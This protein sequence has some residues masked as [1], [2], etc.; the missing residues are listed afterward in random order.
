MEETTN[1]YVLQVLSSETSPLSFTTHKGRINTLLRLCKSDS[2]HDITTKPEKYKSTLEYNV[3]SVTTKRNLVATIMLIN[4]LCHPHLSNSV[5]E[6]WLSYHRLLS[7]T[8]TSSP[9]PDKLPKDMSYDK[10]CKLSKEYMRTKHNT[11]KVY[12][13]SLCLLLVHFIIHEQVNIADLRQVAVSDETN[14]H[15]RQLRLIINDKVCTLRKENKVITLSASTCKS[16]IRSIQFHP[17]SFLFAK[18]NGAVMNNNLFAQF[19][20]RATQ[21]ICGTP[22][23]LLDLKKM[24]QSFSSN[25]FGQ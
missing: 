20:L 18:H 3:S 7:K 5:K 19:I 9:S 25:V 4:K 15:D 14:I 8:Q 16:I 23:G 13:R 21:T 24:K 12:K 17:R 1:E 6:S 22:L 11:H 10:F 2:I